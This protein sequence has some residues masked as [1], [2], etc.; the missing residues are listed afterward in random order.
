MPINYWAAYSSPIVERMIRGAPHS[1]AGRRRI[2]LSLSRRVY[3]SRAVLLSLGRKTAIPESGA[4]TNPRLRDTDF[5]PGEN[6]FAPKLRAQCYSGEGRMIIKMIIKR[7]NMV[8]RTVHFICLLLFA[9]VMLGTPVRA[10]PQIRVSVT[11]GPP[12]LPLYDQPICPADGYIWTPGFWAWDGY[13]YYWVPGT[14]VLAPRPDLFWTPG[15]WSWDNDSF[16]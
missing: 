6:G 1:G 13:D 5:S 8:M 3:L 2:T 11:F 15:Y 10:S 14:W 7:R 9:L 16:I 4:S 12:E